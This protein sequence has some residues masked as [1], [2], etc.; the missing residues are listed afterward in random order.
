MNLPTKN[1]TRDG[2]VRNEGWF[3]KSRHFLWEVSRLFRHRGT[4]QT[5]MLINPAIQKSTR[6]TQSFFERLSVPQNIFVYIDFSDENRRKESSRAAI[7]RVMHG[8]KFGCLA[9]LPINLQTVKRPFFWILI[10]ITSTESLWTHNLF[11]WHIFIFIS[12]NVGNIWFF[13]VRICKLVLHVKMKHVLSVSL[14]LIHLISL[15]DVTCI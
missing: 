9:L 7:R 4:V 10:I 2:H 1:S 6:T 11:P 15:A 13:K 5:L 3:N 14:G 12:K 8:H